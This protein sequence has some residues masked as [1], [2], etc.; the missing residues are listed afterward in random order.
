MAILIDQELCTGCGECIDACAVTALN[1]IGGNVVWS[2]D[3]CTGCGVCVD[4]C[5]ESALTLTEE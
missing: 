4:A 3:D 2:E 5:P 1:T